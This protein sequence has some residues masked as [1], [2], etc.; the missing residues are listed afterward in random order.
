MMLIA[1]DLA[2]WHRSTGG[3][4]HPDVGVWAR[5]PLP[6]DV[7]AGRERCTRNDVIGR[8]ST[9]STHPLAH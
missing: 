3:G 8:S 6:W 4:L 1:A 9:G 5:L 7:L 2:A